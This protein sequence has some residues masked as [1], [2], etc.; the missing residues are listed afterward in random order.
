MCS[1]P[2][3]FNTAFYGPGI[4][5][6]T[7]KYPVVLFLHG[8]GERGSDN[9]KQLVHGSKLFL[10][11]GFRKKHPAIVIFPQCPKDDYWSNVR[12]DRS[13]SGREKFDYQQQAPPTTSL[14]LVMALMDKIV[15]APFTKDDQIYVGGLSMGGMGTFEILSG[16]PGMFA[17]AF[18]ICGGGN[19]ELTDRYAKNTA[20]WVF[21]G[22]RDDVVDPS[23]SKEMV[24]AVKNAGGNPKFTLYKDANHNSW[25]PAFAEPGLLPWVFSH[26]RNDKN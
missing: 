23:F 25:D 4:S 19:P 21:H 1:S 12:I 17:A 16:K 26:K 5:L 2:I 15:A 24:A 11:P 9:T 20:L 8:A 22:A 6:K 3:R 13:K 18:P 7:G 10:N 14:R